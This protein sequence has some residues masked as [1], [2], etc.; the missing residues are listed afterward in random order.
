MRYFCRIVFS[1]TVVFMLLM[2]SPSAWAGDSA[3]PLILEVHPFLPASELIVRFTPLAEYL[4]KAVGRQVEVMMSRDYESH[5]EEVGNGRVDIGYMGPSSYVKLVDKYGPHTLL[6]RLEI[7][8][9]GTFYCVIVGSN[10][11]SVK[12]L[13]DLKGRK[14][15]FGDPMSTMAHFVPRYM[16][17]KAGIKAEDLGSYEFLKNHESIAIGVLSGNFDAGAMK[18][19]TYLAYKDKGLRAIAFSEQYSEHPIV[20]RKDLDPVLIKKLRAAL[21]AL[22][23]TPEAHRIASSINPEASGFGPVSDNEYDNLRDAMKTLEKLGVNP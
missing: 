18:S 11:G 16:L 21:L 14:F 3:K 10:S 2:I 6:G 19:E 1:A 5:I 15:A 7:D 17:Y 9:K 13:A 12:T 8:G 4:S 22:R 23:G 20:A